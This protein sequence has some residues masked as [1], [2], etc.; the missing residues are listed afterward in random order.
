MWSFKPK[1]ETTTRF[2]SRRSLWVLGAVIAAMWVLLVAVHLRLQENSRLSSAYDAIEQG[3]GSLTEEEVE[4]L[5][6]H[7]FD[8]VVTCGE[9]RVA[10]WSRGN[11][12]DEEIDSDAWPKTVENKDALPWIYGAYQVAFGPDNV[13]RA[14]TWNGEA[15]WVVTVD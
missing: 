9:M 12:G 13:L 7:P 1:K 14:M 10:Y 8:L 15:L 5:I 2:A 6:Q 4:K 3:V 11:L